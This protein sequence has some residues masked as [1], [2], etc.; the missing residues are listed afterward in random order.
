MKNKLLRGIAASPGIVIAKAVPYKEEEFLITVREPETTDIEIRKFNRALKQTTKEIQQIKED[1]LKKTDYYHAKIF[2]MQLLVLE[3]KTIIENTVNLIKKGK[4]AEQAVKEVVDKILMAF[5]KVEDE[6]LKARISDFKDVA[7]RVLRNLTQKLPTNALF[8]KTKHVIIAQDLTPSDTATFSKGLVLGFAT[9]SGG[10]TSHTAIMA[11]ALEI[12]AVV[13]LN[14]ITKF[15]KTGDEVIIDGNRG[16]VI[17]DPDEA[18]RRVYEDKIKR[19]QEYTKE[20]EKLSELPAETLDGHSIEL[21]YNIELPEE[22]ES[23]IAHGA[24]GVGLMRTEF[25]YLKAPE[26]PT[27]EEQYEIYKKLA[28]KVAPYSIII[29]TLDL[30][31]DKIFPSLDMKDANPFLGWRAIRCS[32]ANKEMFKTQLR[33]ILRAGKAGNVKMMFPMINSIEEL[34]QAKSCVEKAKKE[35]QREGLPYD[36]DIEIGVMIEIPSAALMARSIAEEVDFLSIGS[37]DLVQYTL[38]CD[39]TNP[40]VAC[41][42]NP[43]HPAVINLIRR[44]IE[45]GHAA[46]VWV[47][48][49]G[50]LGANPIAVPILIGLGIDELSVAPISILEVKKIIRSLSLDEAKT[51]AREIS[52]LETSEAVQK[53]LNK[54]KKK[55]P[56]IEEIISK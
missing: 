53:A 42:Y 18:T 16:V 4:P 43:F 22:I 56:A 27:E 30:G 39:R 21:S 1:F 44:T 33:A 41:L 12:P 54:M 47:G 25:L 34:K 20:L 24:K 14:K 45:A 15:I 35:L 17:I 9:D 49:C 13:G 55:F 48:L 29:R 52:A 36:A 50:E 3:D 8:P 7:A 46:R 6:Y 2:D 51:I 40:R 28:Q 37:N 11:R 10:N 19:F 32:L 26:L 31:G 5:R 38:A 23:G